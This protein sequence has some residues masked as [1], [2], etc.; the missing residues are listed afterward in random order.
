MERWP[1]LRRFGVLAPVAV[2]VTLGVVVVAILASRLEATFRSGLFF[3]L[4]LAAAL[5][6]GVAM[7]A[8]FTWTFKPDDPGPAA[9]YDD[10]PPDP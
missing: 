8:L 4:G 10:G 6:F 2:G 7:A 3:L 1:E 5:V 9:D